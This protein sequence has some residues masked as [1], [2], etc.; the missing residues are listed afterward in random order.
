LYSLVTLGIDGLEVGGV[1]RGL[2]LVVF[3]VGEHSA[4]VRLLATG[5]AGQRGAAEQR[6]RS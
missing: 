6:R 4:E 3:R 5:S 1:A 2:Y